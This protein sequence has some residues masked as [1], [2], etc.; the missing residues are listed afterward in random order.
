MAEVKGN[1][2]SLTLVELGF[3]P[4]QRTAIG[5]FGEE[6]IHQHRLWSVV[7]R[8][9]WKDEQRDDRSEILVAVVVVV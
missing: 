9:L 5:H 8:Q 2:L 7:Y 6:E 4:S 1:V 3:C